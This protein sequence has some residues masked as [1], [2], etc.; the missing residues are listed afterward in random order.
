MNELQA[1]RT[2]AQ[3][4]DSGS[5]AG[6]ARTM[7]TAPAV[8]TRLVQDLE[9]HLGARL[10][11]RTTRRIAL[12]EVGQRFLERIRTVIAAVDDATALAREAQAEPSGRLR[13]RAPLAF[14]NLQL[15]PRLARFQ[16]SHPKVSVELSADGPVAS[17][18]N[19]HD[20]TLAVTRPK[21]EGGFVARLLARS[22]VVLCATPNYL[23]SHGRPHSPA[24]L[25]EHALLLSSTQRALTLQHGNETSAPATLVPRRAPLHLGNGD[26]LQAAALAHLGIAG[27]PSFAVDEALR[28]GRLER[29]L[30]SWR[31]HELSIWACIP[32]R[33]HLPASSRAFLDFLIREFGGRE[34]DPWQDA[35]LPNLLR[36]Q[37]A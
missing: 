27:L 8:T 15:T 26:L 25:A 5:F 36:R 32:T 24:E 17:I 33:Q 7:G 35:E 31:L 30:P 37:A 10:I 11:T 6:A 34:H 18:D 2:L 13:V 16:R 28:S 3:V 19:D 20:V 12:T 23:A 1:M 22:D 14:A 9:R 29:V 4:I 21:L